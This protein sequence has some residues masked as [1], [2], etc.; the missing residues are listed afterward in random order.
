MIDTSVD[1]SSRRS[2][3]VCSTCDVSLCPTTARLTPSSTT[4][5][6]VLFFCLFFSLVCWIAQAAWS[7]QSAGA[8]SLRGREPEKFQ[9]Y[10]DGGAMLCQEV[11][12]AVHTW[13]LRY[14]VIVTLSVSVSAER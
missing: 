11:G 9:V 2:T 10:A 13:R 7:P 4:T 5:T 3:L 6:R 12:T 14:S 1:V 8:Q